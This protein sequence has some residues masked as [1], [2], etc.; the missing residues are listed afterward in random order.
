MS[1]KL[2]NFLLKVIQMLPGPNHIKEEN[3]QQLKEEISEFEKSRRRVWRCAQ[4]E[5]MREVRL[6]LI[7]EME[8]FMDPSKR[9]PESQPWNGKITKNAK[10]NGVGRPNAKIGDLFTVQTVNL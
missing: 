2:N 9:Y 5:F 7:Q 10:P 1:N 3:K 8:W 6:T 4:A